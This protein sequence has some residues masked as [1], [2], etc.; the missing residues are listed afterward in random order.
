[1][2]K[3]S[4]MF[5]ATETVTL[6]ISGLLLSGV[7]LSKIFDVALLAPMLKIRVSVASLT[8]SSVVE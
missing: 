4:E 6:E 5:S 2:V 7:S 1:M 8:V 3:V